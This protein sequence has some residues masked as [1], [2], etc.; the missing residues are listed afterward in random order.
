M[1]LTKQPPRRP[2]NLSM[3]GIVNLARMTDKA[4]AHNEETQGEYIYGME[5]GLDEGLLTFLGISEEDFA[6]AAGRYPDGELV[7]WVEEAADPI[8]IDVSVPGAVA[9]MITRFPA[10]SA[11]SVV[12]ST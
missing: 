4:R 6:D 9:P 2:S 12:L 1:D 11:T 10:A 5:S 7:H 3:G 8:Y